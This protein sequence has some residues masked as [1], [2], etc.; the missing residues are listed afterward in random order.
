MRW[1]LIR[2]LNSRDA[3]EMMVARAILDAQGSNAVLLLRGRIETMRRV[4]DYQH[5]RA[6]AR[7]DQ[8]TTVYNSRPLNVVSVS[9]PPLMRPGP[10]LRVLANFETLL[11]EQ[12]A[13]IHTAKERGW[14]TPLDTNVVWIEA[15]IE[16]RT[17]GRRFE[18]CIR[19]STRAFEEGNIHW[20]GLCWKYALL[21]LEDLVLQL[22]LNIWTTFMRCCVRLVRFGAPEVGDLLMRRLRSL[23]N[24]ISFTAPHRC[25]I[26]ALTEMPLDE[27]VAGGIFFLEARLRVV[28]AT[29]PRNPESHTTCRL[30]LAEERFYQGYGDY[31]ME[32]SEQHLPRVSTNENI[33]SYVRV[34]SSIIPHSML[35]FDYLKAETHLKRCI[36][37]LENPIS[38]DDNSEAY[39]VALATY[40]VMLGAAQYHQEHLLEA[41]ESYTKALKIHEDHLDLHEVTILD[42][43]QVHRILTLLDWLSRVESNGGDPQSKTS[44]H[45]RQAQLEKNF[46]AMVEQQ[47]EKPFTTS[48]EQVKSN[49]K[50]RGTRKRPNDSSTKAPDQINTFRQ[51]EV[52]FTGKSSSFR[53]RR[54]EGPTF[55]DVD[56]E[57]WGGRQSIPSP[58]L[59]A[60]SLP[61]AQ[62]IET[63][64]STSNNAVVETTGSQRSIAW[65]ILSGKRSISVAG[66]VKIEMIDSRTSSSM[67]PGGSVHAFSQCRRPAPVPPRPTT[68]WC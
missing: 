3:A 19:E 50:I 25:F 9:L 61:G 63:V 51:G 52:D 28:Q 57:R 45:G 35:R 7:R 44:Y 37:E 55:D 26:Y 54:S 48:P 40:Y 4:H 1:G 10:A 33:S 42:V 27:L 65:S 62:L 56:V 14:C 11:R 43:P 58:V 53:P 21:Q 22:D 38:E 68:P 29:W 47:S 17:P 60:K 66:N 8:D 30:N 24:R 16:T 2:K 15:H 5:R 36:A 23:R 67:L 18:Q 64:K 34:S 12:Q 6:R 59:P 31:I 13:L 46:S 20:A 32:L 39:A 41:K 49:R